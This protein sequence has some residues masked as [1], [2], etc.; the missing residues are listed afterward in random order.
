MFSLLFSYPV[1]LFVFL[2][3]L[4]FEILNLKYFLMLIKKCRLIRIDFL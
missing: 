2:L 4:K 3:N 1:F